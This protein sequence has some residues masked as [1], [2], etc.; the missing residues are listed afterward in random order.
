[1]ASERSLAQDDLVAAARGLATAARLLERALGDMTLPQFRVLG[2]VASSP[3]RASRIAERAAVSRPSLSG[4][5]DGLESRQWVRRSVVDGDRRGVRLD[6][7]TGGRHALAGACTAAGRAVSEILDE[8]E[9][10]DRAAAVRGLVLL[11]QAFDRRGARRVAT[12]GTA[13]R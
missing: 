10:D 4:V 9:P 11:A 2:V 13:A 8:L 12:E 3:E 1:V 6:V 7:T 5:L